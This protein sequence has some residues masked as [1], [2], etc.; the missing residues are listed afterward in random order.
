MTFKRATCSEPR[1]VINVVNA[2][3]PGLMVTPARPPLTMEGYC[4]IVLPVVVYFVARSAIPG[5]DPCCR[6]HIHA[7]RERRECRRISPE[8]PPLPQLYH[9]LAGKRNPSRSPAR[10]HTV[11]VGSRHG[12]ICRFSF[13]GLLPVK[14]LASPIKLQIHLTVQLHWH[15]M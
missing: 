2:G 3:S 12:V 11:P 8:R 7:G 15:T 9:G 1:P 13:I 4:V 5:M 10:S 14:M 6:G